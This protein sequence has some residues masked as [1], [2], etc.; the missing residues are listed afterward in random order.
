M[1]TC[2]KPGAMPVFAP[3]RLSATW[4]AWVDSVPTLFGKL[5]EPPFGDWYMNRLPGWPGE[6]GFTSKSVVL[7][8]GAST[9]F[10]MTPFP[11]RDGARARNAVTP[12]MSIVLWA[13][14]AATSHPQ[15]A[16]SKISRFIGKKESRFLA[17]LQTEECAHPGAEDAAGHS[18]GHSEE[19]HRP[20]AEGAG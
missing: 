18:D 3:K 16:Q 1:P 2:C 15:R 12:I 14:A 11:L 7:N 4:S 8:S 20:Y 9:C 19:E 17:V 6:P 10:T 13:R 5:A